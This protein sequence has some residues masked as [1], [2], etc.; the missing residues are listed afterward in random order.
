MN[1]QK[2]YSNIIENLCTNRYMVLYIISVTRN[3][4][5]PYNNALS[6]KKKKNK[7]PIKIYI[8]IF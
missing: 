7:G 5:H 2:S 1:I 3:L 6:K 8:K 4:Q